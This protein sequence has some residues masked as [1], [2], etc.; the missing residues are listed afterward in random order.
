MHNKEELKNWLNNLLTDLKRVSRAI[1]I[2]DTS[3]LFDAFDDVEHD[4]TRLAEA[5]DA[6][7]SPE[8]KDM[9]KWAHED[10]DLNGAPESEEDR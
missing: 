2:G 9:D 10:D 5:V 1:D 4:Y 8:E 3:D 7:E 6:L